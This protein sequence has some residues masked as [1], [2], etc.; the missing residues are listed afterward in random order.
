M[1]IRSDP[2]WQTR[3]GRWAA[4]FG[5]SNIGAALELY[6]NPPR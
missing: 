3:F 6:P 2:R 5:V 4:D 1:P